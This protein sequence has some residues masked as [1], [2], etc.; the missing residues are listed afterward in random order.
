MKKLNALNSGVKKSIF[1]ILLPGLLLFSHLRL[2]GQYVTKSGFFTV[3]MDKGKTVLVSEKHGDTVAG[4]SYFNQMNRALLR[5]RSLRFECYQVMETGAD[6]ET[7]KREGKYSVWMKKGNLARV[8]MRDILFPDDGSDI[9]YDGKNLWAY[10]VGKNATVCLDK[11]TIL[12]E[13]KEVYMT[14]DISRGA[15]LSHDIMNFGS[16]VSM[17]VL[18]LSK[19]FGYGSA[20]EDGNM[21]VAYLG[22]DTVNGEKMHHIKV[23]LVGGQRI[24]DYWISPADT[25]PR[26]MEEKLVM[27]AANSSL[28]RELWS[29]VAVN[30]ELPDSLFAWKPPEN[31]KKYTHP[32]Q[33]VMEDSLGRMEQN[34]YE[35]F[36]GLSL[37]DGG[38]FN[39]SDYKGQLVLLVFWRLGC[40]PCLKEMPGL[41]QL[42]EKYKDK[43]FTV[44]GF[45][46]V[47][48]EALVKKYL[49]KNG[50]R[51][52]N[53][54]DPSAK[55]KKIYEEF[56]TNIVP[57]N[58]LIDREGFLI[59][60]WYGYDPKDDKPEKILNS[61][62]LPTNMSH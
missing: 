48:N 27:N 6:G 15:S 13:V 29:H 17:P 12:G 37:T 52:P 3:T 25:L 1:I 4:R 56:K 50:I 30:E 7:G 60:L 45:N 34:L 9:I 16:S 59:T 10:F 5:A 51:F 62:F 28:R 49:V 11:N 32:T 35:T 47:D 14:K 22:E 8:E 41:Q 18:Y 31:W 24:A 54:L 20:L 19:F 21:K 39:L 43:G 42:F 61:N 55:A 2:A 53:I 58:C 33:E 26:K 23:V 46:H 40:P 44:V 36:K 38:T 57:L